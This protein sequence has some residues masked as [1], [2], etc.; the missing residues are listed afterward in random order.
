MKEGGYYVSKKEKE[1][2]KL[3]H[4]K[5]LSSNEAIRLVELDGWYPDPI[6]N[7]S[8]TSHLQFHHKIKK[9]KV[10]IPANR[11]TLHPDTQETILKQAGLTGD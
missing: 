11:K 10:T 4:K 2:Q 3:L 1:L 7:K 9:G 8:G 5:I 6:N